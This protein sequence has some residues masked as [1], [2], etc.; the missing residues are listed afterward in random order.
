MRDFVGWLVVVEGVV[1]L[2][3]CVLAH[4]KLKMVK[5][6]R[7]FTVLFSFVYHS[8]PKKRLQSEKPNK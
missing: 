6:P 8:N 4:K 2:W 3:S 1:V 7:L 5:V